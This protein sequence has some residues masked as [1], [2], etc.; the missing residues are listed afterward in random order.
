M[1]TM[2]AIICNP[3]NPTNLEYFNNLIFGPKECFITNF[4]LSPTG[5]KTYRAAIQEHRKVFMDYKKWAK[6]SSL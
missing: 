5:I 4:F 3:N 6:F 2:Q 1:I